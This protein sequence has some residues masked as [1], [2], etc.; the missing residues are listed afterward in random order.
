MVLIIPSDFVDVCVYF[1]H[2]PLHRDTSPSKHTI[3]TIELLTSS[4]LTPSLPFPQRGLQQLQNSLGS[5]GQNGPDK[6][7]AYSLMVQG[8]RTSPADPDA[9][10]LFFDIESL[11]GEALLFF[12]WGGGTSAGEGEDWGTYSGC[13]DG[14]LQGWLLGVAVFV[15]LSTGCVGW[16]LGDYRMMGMSIISSL[17]ETNHL[18][19]YCLH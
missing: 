12:F 15:R 8:L 4:R 3:I 19:I 10:V 1:L 5:Q 11:I 6:P 13:S 16:K 18:A 7:R 14:M 9:H 17:P 2:S